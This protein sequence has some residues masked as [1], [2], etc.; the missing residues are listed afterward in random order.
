M[1]HCQRENLIPVIQH[2]P[3][4]GVG[5]QATLLEHTG[6]APVRRQGGAK[7]LVRPAADHLLAPYRLL[8]MS[9]VQYILIRWHFLVKPNCMRCTVSIECGNSCMMRSDEGCTKGTRRVT[10]VP[11]LLLVCSRAISNFCSHH[12][13]PLTENDQHFGEPSSTQKTN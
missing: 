3:H 5:K 1:T 11:W 2:N 12:T 4:M 10:W 7:L 13:W 8:R 9:D 6:T